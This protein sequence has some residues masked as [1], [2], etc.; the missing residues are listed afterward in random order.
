MARICGMEIVTVEAIDGAM[1]FRPTPH[2]DDRGFFS[3][4]FDADVARAVGLDPAAFV[5]DSMS[6]SKAGVVRGMHARRGEGEAKLVRCSSGAIFDVIV[7]LRWTSPTFLR[8]ASFVLRGD[9]QV[10]L[11]VPPGCAH[12]FQ[13]LSDPADVAYRI[14]RAH[15]PNEDIAIA[16]DDPALG[17]V[18]PLP[19][20]LQSERDRQAGTLA[21][22]LSALDWGIWR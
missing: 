5:Q 15:D 13:A 6:R 14:N 1:L 19:V 2:V 4:T 7:D 12:G 22:A 9:E 11:Y 17:I 18:W 21:D 3:R 20:T 8:H 16:F 10:S